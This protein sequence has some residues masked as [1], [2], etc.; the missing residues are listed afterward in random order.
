MSEAV[1]IGPTQSIYDIENKPQKQSSKQTGELGKDEFL[2]LLVT[3]LQYQDPLKPMDDKEF[4]GQMAQ[5]SALEQMQN[6]N[7]SFSVTKA[8]NLV[9]KYA[10]GKLVVDD[11]E[12]E[13]AGEVQSI[14]V[15]GSKSYAVINGQEIL[16][17]DILEVKNQ[18]NEEKVVDLSKYT[19]LIGKNVNSIVKGLEEDEVYQL[20]GNVHSVSIAQNQPI[21]ILNGINTI[22]DSLVLNEE[23]KVKV[24]TTKEYLQGKVGQLVTAVITDNEG[25]KT[26]ITGKVALVDGD[27][28]KPKVTFDEVRTMVDSIYEIY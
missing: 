4:I 6:L 7:A 13:V 14:K 2:R 11:K 24:T 25:K 16:V 20:Q 5:F 10:V 26:K 19:G 12:E 1:K 22:I 9:G 21:V 23:E 17:D 8:L 27:D 15:A 18:L 3:Q 28:Q